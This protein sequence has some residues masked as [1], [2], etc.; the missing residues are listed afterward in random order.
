V[1]VF[2]EI[3]KHYQQRDLAAREWKKNGGKVVGYFCNNVPE[4]LIL[5]AGFFPYRLSSDPT[6]GTGVARQ[7]DLPRDVE[8]EEFVLNMLNMA[9]IS[10]YDFTDYIIVPHARTTISGLYQLLTVAKKA[11][12]AL[13]IPELYFF[14]NLN[15]TFYTSQVYNRD[16]FFEFKIQLEKWAEKSI[17]NDSLAKAINVTNENKMLL[18]QVA[19]LRAADPPRVSGAEALQL[20]GTSMFML[21]QDHNKLL[22]QYLDD[23]GKLQARKGIRL[24][25]GGSP[26]DNLQFYQIVESLGATIIS[27]DNCWGNRYTDVLVKT[28][29]SSPFEAVVDRYNNNSP[30][31][32]IFPII[33]RVN[34]CVDSAIDAKVQGAI[35]YNHE[36]DTH[37]WDIPD[38]VKA[39]KEKGI[40][41]LYL[42]GQPYKISDPEPLTT[43]IK[44][45][46]QQIGC[47]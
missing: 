46:I 36:N 25:F 8:I 24:F 12:P 43:K 45:F 44:E 10:H 34:Y 22:H 29:I 18:K 2:E 14:D 13:K 17:Y 6:G 31:P 27:E 26:Q 28:T 30:C 19:A 23:A 39:L 11:N 42:K 40:P 47:V 7:Q 16:R 33:R 35:F 20:I 32:R 4:E 3:Q 38:E 21:K 9:L 41:S 5:A 15:T 37:A 1:T